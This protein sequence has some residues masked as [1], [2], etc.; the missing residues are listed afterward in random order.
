LKPFDKNGAFQSAAE[1]TT[2]RRVAVRSAGVTMLS[3]GLG[4][5]FQIFSVVIL[6]RLLT[7]ADFGL[8]T[9]V[10]TFSL[11]LSNFGVNGFTESVLQR[12][13]IDHRLASNLF[14]INLGAGILLTLAFAAAG[15]LMAR[16]YGNP[17]VAHVAVGI[18]LT[19]L[20]TS[21]S[22][23]HLSLLMRAM[24]FTQV[25]ANDFISRIASI[26]ISILLAW[27]G[28]GYWALVAGA[29][30]Q[31]V[32][33]AIGAWTM[34]RW[35]PGL[36]RRADG[37]GSMVGFAAHVYGRF[38]LN[39]FSRNMDNLLVGWRFN[40]QSLGFYKKAYDLFALS[41]LTQNLT[42]VTVSAL[43]KL[44]GDSQQYKRFL[45][46]ALSV[47]AFLGMALG[48][49]L[50][51]IGKDLIHFLLGPRWDPAGRIFTFFGPGI[52][53]LF[54]CGTQSWI[55]LSIGK[56]NRWFRW[57]WIEFAVTGL[58]FVVGLHWGPAGVAM[59]WSVSLCILTLPALWYAGSPI[60]L[61]IAPLLNTVW[62][63]IVASAVAGIATVAITGGP[64]SFV[65]ASTAIGNIARMA[66]LSSIFGVLYLGAVLLLYQSFKPFNQVFGLLRDLG[67]GRRSSTP[68]QA[69]TPTFQTG[70]TEEL[71]LTNK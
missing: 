58:L 51:L 28:W 8:V 47:T 54:L 11:L 69:V 4:M 34:C 14:W 42:S 29:V 66:K 56:A 6:A 65:A 68:S 38:T 17:R 5:A 52:G 41:A 9:M 30:T 71:S 7:P 21:T 24:R 22:V 67:P 64:A 2:L 63:Y 50:T 48:G 10:T 43:S 49:D 15:S 16:F 19:I 12:A 61:G 1:V 57:S 59:S 25:S 45:L 55:H 46:S 37:T 26:S 31:P 23:L 40:A 20:I 60:Q 33:Q 39:Y 18:S 36:P 53:M 27:A 44:R 13:E 32:S 35:V 70:T 62:K 3:Q